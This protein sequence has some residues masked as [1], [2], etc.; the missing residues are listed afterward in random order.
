MNIVELFSGSGTISKEFERRGHKVF[1]IDIRQRRGICEP[2]LRK[3]IM[4]L[5]VKEIP[6]KKV[7]VIWA[8]PPCDVFSK[9]SGDLHWDKSGNPK[10]EKCLN[11]IRLLKKTLKFI[12][13]I[14][15]DHFFIENPDGRMKYQKELVNFL[16]RNHGKTLRIHYENYGFGTSKPTTIFTNALDYFGKSSLDVS[17]ERN[18]ALLSNLTKCQ[19]QAIPGD[20]AKEIADYC[21]IYTQ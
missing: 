15:P 5:K 20:L 10:T 14:N 6:F 17:A 13:K 16:M 21:E 4:D 8:S 12:E 9:A 7:H 3:D 18:V 2:S 1:S 19:K 11:H